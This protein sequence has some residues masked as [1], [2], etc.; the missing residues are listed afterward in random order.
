[1]RTIRNLAFVV[2]LCASFAAMQAHVLAMGDAITDFC[3]DWWHAHE[4]YECHKDEGCPPDWQADGSC[5]FSHIEDEEEMLATAAA[6]CQEASDAC[7]LT[8]GEEY[9]GFVT[10]WYEWTTNPNDPCYEALIN[11]ENWIT[12]GQGSC[13]AGAN[14]DWSCDC[15]AFFWGE[16]EG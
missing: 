3:D 14:S 16:C 5:D 4:C 8:C 11:P 1:M 6:Y 13:N 15:E 2:M 12:W 9:A 7:D 10:S